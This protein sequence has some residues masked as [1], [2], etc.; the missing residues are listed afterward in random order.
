M[1]RKCL[2]YV[3]LDGYETPNLR[4]KR[5]YVNKKSWDSIPDVENIE[6]WGFDGS[7]TGQA[8][9]KFSD[10][11]LSPVKVYPDPTC[12]SDYLV[13][14]EVLNSD[15]TPHRH[16]N[17]SKLEGIEQENQDLEMWFG[18]EQEYVFM[19]PHTDK[20]YSF[21]ERGYP[22]PQGRYYC[23]VGADVAPLRHIVDTHASMLD[24][25]GIPIEGTNAEVMLSQWEYQIGPA[26]ALDIADDLWIARY[27]LEILG[28]QEGV[29]ISLNPK[30]I[31]GDWNGSG[32][33]INFSTK[34]MREVK[35]S[36]YINDVIKSFKESHNE[37]IKEY[38][39]GNEKR[40][41]GNHETQHIKRFTHGNSDRGAS[42]RI[43]PK[44]S[45]EGV[46]YLE[47]RRP[48]A[49][50]NPYRAVASII[51]TVASVGH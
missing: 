48:A 11:V 20:P 51:Q 31:R 50:M 24:L 1:S 23:G 5:R 13:L 2:T 18:I 17:R 34:Y 44:L 3:W 46:G 40:L 30:P 27:I 29:A 41:T 37:H 4:S 38:G 19:D 7:S 26:S 28:E 14:C 33:H 43:P 36:N 10:C 12:Q 42:I 49:N 25:I 47:D 15:G 39:I 45:K 35:D 32:A 21:P 16:N 9:G 22:N 8:E 6:K